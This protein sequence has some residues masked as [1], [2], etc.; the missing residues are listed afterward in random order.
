MTGRREQEQSINVSARY[1][2]DRHAHAPVTIKPFQFRGWFLTA[3]SLRIETAPVTP[4]FY[5][6]LDAQLRATPQ[7][8]AD[9]PLVLDL[10]DAPAWAAPEA[11]D[12]LVDNLRRR[13]LLVFGVQNAGT[14]TTDDLARLGLI[15]IRGGRSAP[16]PG[17][18]STRARRIETLLAP[19]NKVIHSPVR[20]GQLVVAEQG[21]LTVIGS[22]ASG[23]E[24]VAGGNI[25]VYGPLRGRAMAGVH[26]DK[27]ARIFC[28]SL[29]AELVAIAG[30]YKTSDSLDGA[31]KG[32]CM[33]IFLENG[34]LRMELLG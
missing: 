9:A 19:D 34:G 21:D 10:G 20:S 12:A 32:H 14:I 22:V 13:N 26:G 25:H 23:A 29:E 18:K 2:Q 1:D 31:P 24:L 5:D 28:Q 7:F 15:P 30:L 3:L 33:Q 16:Q 11:L 6:A 4:T 17:E 27:N 8:F